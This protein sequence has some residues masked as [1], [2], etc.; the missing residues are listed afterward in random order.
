MKKFNNKMTIELKDKNGN[1]VDSRTYGN[2][3]TNGYLNLVKSLFNPAFVQT[4]S[5]A[6]DVMVNYTPRL[7]FGGVQMFDNY[8][9]ETKDTLAVDSVLTRGTAH[10]G[11]EY[12][13]A[14]PTR[15]TLLTNECE[16]T[17]EF[18]KF[19]WEWGTNKG[20]G[21]HKSI[22]LMPINGGNAG[23]TNGMFN[24]NDSTIVDTTLPNDTNAFMILSQNTVNG[25]S[26]PFI[27][28]SGTLIGVSPDLKYYYTLRGYNQSANPLNAAF[29][30]VWEFVDFSNIRMN[31]Y[32][33]AFQPSIGF[34]RYR[35]IQIPTFEKESGS[36]YNWLSYSFNAFDNE[37]YLFNVSKG[38]LRMFNIETLETK[39][40]VLKLP[41]DLSLNAS[42][43]KIGKIGKWLYVNNYDRTYNGRYIYRFLASDGSF[44]DKIN[45]PYPAAGTTYRDQTMWQY[46]PNELFV[47]IDTYCWL[48]DG[49]KMNG[50]FYNANT[51]QAIQKTDLFPLCF[52]LTGNGKFAIA[53]H[54]L[55]TVHNFDAPIVK[56]EGMTMTLTYLI[57]HA[58]STT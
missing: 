52:A 29:V 3:I 19:K 55:M 2:I 6:R 31:N 53:N 25:D 44:I 28:N 51:V 50:V 4:S 34:Q 11:G 27:S 13:G 45:I 24:L 38:T 14:D 18:I 16:F 35:S 23:M 56:E 58:D 57:Q 46:S 15:G 47:N 17:D 40:V 39:E 48:F 43:A 22:A 26:A 30:D 36:A 7:A 33:Y 5:S 41:T 54:C 37:L 9:N 49:E 21:T 32:L 10:A 20:N 8:I 42:S 12:A 1:V